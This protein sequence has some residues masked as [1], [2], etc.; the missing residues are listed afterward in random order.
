[1]ARKSGKKVVKPKDLR[2]RG[3]KDDARGKR[4][5]ST[6]RGGASKIPKGIQTSPSQTKVIV[7]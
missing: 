3:V 1:M 6:V 2:A 4:E 7:N 5:G